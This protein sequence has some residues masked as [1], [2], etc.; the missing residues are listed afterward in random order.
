MCTHLVIVVKYLLY[1]NQ[2]NDN[3]LASDHIEVCGYIHN[4][5]SLNVLN[6]RVVGLM[7]IQ[8]NIDPAVKSNI[9]LP[10]LNLNWSSNFI[11]IN[12]SSCYK[13][14]ISCTLV[15]DNLSSILPYFIKNKIDICLFDVWVAPT[16]CLGHPCC[17]HQTTKPCK[18]LLFSV[19]WL[20]TGT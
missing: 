18:S 12:T 20:I 17:I 14:W 9:M 6:V 13:S 16:H 19:Y 2:F 4:V 7:S 10:L 1:K 15:F 3:I 5:Y 11:L 8:L